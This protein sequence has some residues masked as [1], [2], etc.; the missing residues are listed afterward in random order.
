MNRTEVERTE[1]ASGKQPEGRSPF[2]SGTVGSAAS[3]RRV[4]VSRTLYL[5][6]TRG[7][8]V[9]CLVAFLVLEA[10]QGVVFTI[11]ATEDF[12]FDFLIILPVLLRAFG[13]AVTYTLP[14]ALLFGTGLFVGRLMADREITALRSFGLSAQQLVTPV[15]ILGGLLAIL[16]VHYNHEV[17]P[18]LRLANRNVGVQILEQLGYLGEGWNFEYSPG[19][20]ARKLWIHHYNGPS[21]EGIFLSVAGEGEGAPVSKETLEKVETPSYP[22][23]L[24]AEKGVVYRGTGKLAGRVVVS[25]KGV[26]LFFDNEFLDPDTPSDFMNRLRMEKLRWSPTLT[27]KSPGTKDLPRAGLL[28]KIELRRR[29]AQEAE[30]AGEDPAIIEKKQED[31]FEA[32]AAYYRRYSLAFAAFTFPTAAFILGLFLRSGNRLLPFFISSSVVPAIY[33]FF[34]LAGGKLAESGVFPMITQQLGNLLLLG[35]SGVLFALVNR[36]PR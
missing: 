19:R 11:R 34:E 10:V 31:Y 18:R 32:L 14:V 5:Y 16:S 35:F 17:V 28:Q 25:L 15:V 33:F 2:R 4:R 22:I 8:I 27:R 26:N 24:F 36:G 21:L 30:A 3:P 7:L 13:Q 29:E 23:Y 9:N 20:S 6:F 1:S 12:S